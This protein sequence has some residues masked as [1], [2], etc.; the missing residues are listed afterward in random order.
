[1]RIS[2]KLF[3][4]LLFTFCS[5]A[6]H[7][8]KV[9]FEVDVDPIVSVGK[10]FS[11][12]F[13][14]N[15][16]PDKVYF[17]TPNLD[18]DGIDV[19]AGPSD[20]QKKS[21]SIT[22]GNMVSN[23]AYINTYVLIATKP[24]VYKIPAVKAMV[25]GKE[26][27][28][29][30][31]PFEAV[32]EQQPPQG[33]GG[34]VQQGGTRPTGQSSSDDLLLRVIVSKTSVYKWQPIRV[35]FKLYSRVRIAGREGLKMPSLNGFWKEELPTEHYDSQQ[36]TYNSKVYESRIVA[37]YLLYPQQAG[38]L[39]I[40]PMEM[41]L[42]TLVTQRRAPQ[43]TFDAFFGGVQDIKNESRKVSTSPVTINVNDWPSGAPSS[44]NGAVGNFS[45][46]SDFPEAPVNI[47]T[48]ANYIFR[49]SGTGNYPLLTQAP[50]LDIP[51]SF[52]QYNVQS[53]DNLNPT[54]AG[55]SGFRQFEYPLI[56]RAEG[57][58][59][60]EPI[61]FTYFN[62]E[63]AK[64]VTLNTK[65]YKVT[66]LPDSTGG[67][68]MSSGNMVAGISKEDIKLLG[69]DIRF[70]KIGT[71]GL[72]MKGDMFMGSLWYFILLFLII[73]LFVFALIYLQ[74]RIKE[75]SNIDLIRGKRANKV[76]L[77]RLKAA[78]GYMK[79]GSQRNF[80]E[81]M[82]KALWGYMSD[83]LNI[84]SAILTKENIREELLKHNISQE[85]VARYTDLITNCEY[86]Q[87][88][89]S[90]SGH[91]HE[92]Y[93]NAVKAISKLESLIKR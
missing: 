54:S 78:E 8:Q 28:T 91:M 81:E 10:V 20:A 30:E 9:T 71:A 66:V 35:Y 76:A 89:P 83:K 44:F 74:K 11:V 16:K 92:I 79:E 17:A 87:Y 57:E 65:E 6:V 2:K 72:V 84:P 31:V 1:M 47:N 90:G 42:A 32:A 82:L 58:Y 46:T 85:H 88:S 26:Y 38:T 48:S 40:D 51:G 93:A 34:N 86:A 18:I 25:D 52:Q 43:T 7:A 77:Q 5:A 27:T 62:P 36:E 68:I 15:S 61:R 53:R 12:E 69:E 19:V 67:S 70:I 80:Y 59:T 23:E 14:L 60:I 21:V 75:M 37:E 22:N 24:G 39:K 49:L 64:Y 41:T 4:I 56:P 50:E 73:G 63:T 45:I 55:T 3:I 29:K 13:V 33:T